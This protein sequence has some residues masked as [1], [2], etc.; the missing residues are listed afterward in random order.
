MNVEAVKCET[1]PS[2]V[3]LLTHASLTAPNVRLARVR[4]RT[5]P[6]RGGTY[7]LRNTATVNNERDCV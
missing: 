7:T 3:A 6:L 1:L 2:L 4:A 5:A